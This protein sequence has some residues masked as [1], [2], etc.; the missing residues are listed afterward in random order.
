MGDDQ[1]PADGAA[2]GRARTA[3]RHEFFPYE[4]DAQFLAGAME[5]AESAADSGEL[6]LVAVTEPKQRLLRTKLAALRGPPAVAFMQTGTLG[7][8]PGRLIPAWRAWLDEHR[9]DGRAV[10]A[11]GEPPRDKSDSAQA[12]ELLLHE[13]LLNL[14][15]AQ[16]APWWL[17][18]P[19]DTQVL[20]DTAIEAAGNCH[21]LILT[22][23]AHEP[24]PGY[25]RVPHAAGALPP[26][27]EPNRALAYGRD[28]LKAVRDL[29]GVAA[30]RHGVHGARLQDLL[31]AASEVAANSILYGGAHGTLRVWTAGSAVIC[32]FHDSGYISDPL[33]GRVRPRPDQIGGRGLWLVQQLCDLVQLRSSAEGGTTVR[34]HMHGSR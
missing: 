3:F 32:E 10:R 4:G 7:N 17:L 24:R 28:D 34:L 21:P 29:V 8:N 30:D 6:V 22:G 23:G 18:C 33:V 15:F 31:I 26:P 14:A 20:S 11:I 9:E 25:A 1:A 19:Y 5:F 12:A 16:S 27:G 2:G 13:R